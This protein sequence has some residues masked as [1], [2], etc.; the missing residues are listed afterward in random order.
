MCDLIF[1]FVI[2]SSIILFSSEITEKDYI[3]KG[4]NKE[5]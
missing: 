5:C 2:I 3:Q 1:T 4:P